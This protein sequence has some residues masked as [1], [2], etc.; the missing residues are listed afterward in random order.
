MYEVL[1]KLFLL[2]MVIPFFF[3]G[4]AGKQPSL[5]DANS[6][7]NRGL[8]NINQNKPK[9]A[10]ADFTKAIELNPSEAKGYFLRGA[11][12]SDIFEYK[13]AVND[14]S[15]VI[16]ITPDFALA[17]EMRAEAYVGLAV[18]GDI[19]DS[20]AEETEEDFNKF[21]EYYKFAENDFKKVDELDPSFADFNLYRGIGYKSP[22]T[23]KFMIPA[24][25]N[26]SRIIRGE[27][28]LG[29]TT[30]EEAKN[31]LP[32]WPGH[33]PT[34]YKYQETPEEVGKVKEVLKKTKYTYNPMS[35]DLLLVFDKNKKLIAVESMFSD[36]RE[37]QER[38]NNLIIKN[39]FNEIPSSDSFYKTM[40]GEVAPCITADL[41]KYRESADPLITDDDK[42]IIFKVTY[43]YT[44]Q[45]Q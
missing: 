11:V 35:C 16:E 34:L 4:C 28:I 39:K 45:P 18:E 14:F 24:L 13:K 36:S 3:T 32:P 29:I 8:N 2:M 17:Y 42:K 41:Y 9:R 37:A 31:M 5:S 44:C 30:L 1:R 6:Y 7:L 12:Y 10:I 21:E 25:T 22:T 38:A 43:Y 20:K 40:R 23:N 33:D 26:F 19:Y 27:L 15:K